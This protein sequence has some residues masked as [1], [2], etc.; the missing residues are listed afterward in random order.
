MELSSAGCFASLPDCT[1]VPAELKPF[2]GDAFLAWLLILLLDRESCEGHVEP[3]GAP[4]PW[5]ALLRG[6]VPTHISKP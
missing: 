1:N 6:V 2:P 5:A 3:R 4:G